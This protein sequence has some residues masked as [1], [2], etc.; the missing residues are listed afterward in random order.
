MDNVDI[1]IILLPNGTIEFEREADPVLRDVLR[2][3]M[4]D[5]K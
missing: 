2:E 1:E 5:E 4:N 3:N